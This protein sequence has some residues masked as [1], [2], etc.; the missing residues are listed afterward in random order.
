[1]EP[2]LSALQVSHH[3]SAAVTMA[4]ATAMIREHA[5]SQR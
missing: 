2:S 5:N 3:N 4:T 1:M